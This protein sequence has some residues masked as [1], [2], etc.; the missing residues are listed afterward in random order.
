MVNWKI[1]HINMIKDS[2]FMILTVSKSRSNSTLD[3]ITFK[4]SILNQQLEKRENKK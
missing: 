3:L 1:D 2:I 4:W